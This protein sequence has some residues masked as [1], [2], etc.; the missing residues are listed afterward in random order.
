MRV[1]SSTPNRRRVRTSLPRKE[2]AQLI[3]SLP[4]MISGRTPSRYGLHKLFWGAVAFSLFTDIHDAFMVKAYGLPDELGDQWD[5]LSQHTKAYKRPVER[6][7]VSKQVY[8]RYQRNHPK[9][10]MGK[11]SKA[12]DPTRA[13]SGLGLL[14]QSQYARW[15]QLF[16][17]IYHSNKNRMSAGAAK[18]LAGQIAWT[19]L[20]EE[21]AQTMWEVLGNRQGLLILRVSDRLSESVAPGKFDPLNGYYKRNRDQVFILSRGRIELGTQVPYAAQVDKTRRLWPEDMA[22]WIDRAVAFGRDKVM[23]KVVS[24]LQSA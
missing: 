24:I 3:R 23:D 11:G 10:M 8:N 18:S 12:H 1:Q 14:T 4:G 7:S 21:G 17:T 9:R 16:G 19:R 6:G 5:D 20:K 2:V 13:G 15:Q 22:P